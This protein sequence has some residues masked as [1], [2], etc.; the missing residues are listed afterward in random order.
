MHEQEPQKNIP[1]PTVPIR[2]SDYY[3]EVYLPQT[4]VQKPEF[5]QTAS[6]SNIPPVLDA[7]DKTP[8]ME[9]VPVTLDIFPSLYAQPDEPHEFVD[10][11]QGLQI[12]KSG[13]ILALGMDLDNMDD[14]ERQKMRQ[15]QRLNQFR[16][17]TQ[18]MD[19]WERNLDGSLDSDQVE[20]TRDL[21]HTYKRIAVSW[22]TGELSTE[23]FT[24][25]SADDILDER[26]PTSHDALATAE[27]EIRLRSLNIPDILREADE[28]IH[29][30]RNKTPDTDLVN[31]VHDAKKDNID[32][33][34]TDKAQKENS[35]RT[36][37]VRKD[38]K[39]GMEYIGKIENIQKSGILYVY[40]KDLDEP[41]EDAAVFMSELWERKF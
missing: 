2:H 7:I 22:Y 32:S 40:D 41:S 10:D 17:L 33:E 14:T 37:E 28:I 29:P 6:L 9:F 11:E 35:D 39:E 3:P 19:T 25:R 12:A 1:H 34:S 27:R 38:L 30:K 24:K 26:F 18:I 4:I 15:V 23:P 16:R 21:L 13:L 36:A 31:Q 20:S 8:H 5:V